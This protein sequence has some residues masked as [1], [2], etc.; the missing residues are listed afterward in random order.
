M[1]QFPFYFRAMETKNL[2]AVLFVSCIFLSICLQPTASQG[3]RWGREFE[4][5]HPRWKTVK[6][7]YRRK[8]LHER[9]FDTSAEK[10]KDTIC[11][12]Q[13]EVTLF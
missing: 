2:V 11:N 1:C 4:E 6:S 8:N 7:D 9:K 10:G 13:K 3:L 5:E 12:K